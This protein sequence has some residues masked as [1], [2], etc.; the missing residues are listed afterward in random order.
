MNLVRTQILLTGEQ[1]RRLRRLAKAR[2][3]SVSALVR[4]IV[5][6]GLAEHEGRKQDLFETLEESAQWLE[7][8]A[9]DLV[10]TPEDLQAMREERDHALGG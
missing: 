4:E 3:T 7:Q 9:P 2:E 10:H 5:D 1:L 6:Q 8:H